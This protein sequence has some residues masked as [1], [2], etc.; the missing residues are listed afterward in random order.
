[1]EFGDKLAER[2]KPCVPLDAS[3]PLQWPLIVGILAVVLMVLPLSPRDAEITA[4]FSFF[5]GLLNAEPDPISYPDSG[6]ERGA[7]PHTYLMTKFTPFRTKAMSAVQP[8]PGA[9]DSP[10]SRRKCSALGE[11]GRFSTCGR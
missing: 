2:I 3:G 8:L 9:V 7:E 1:V 5:V 6:V 4:C 10:K 11:G